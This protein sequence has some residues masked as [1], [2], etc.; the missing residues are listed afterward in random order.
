MAFSPVCG[1][2]FR[3]R[4][5]EPMNLGTWHRRD[6]TMSVHRHF[7]LQRPP[8][9]GPPDPHF[10]YKSPSHD[11]ALATLQYMLVADKRCCAVVGE[12]GAGKT[13][14]ARTLCALVSRNRIILWSDSI[15]SVDPRYGMGVAVYAR[16]GLTQ[17]PAERALGEIP[18]SRWRPRGRSDSGAPLLIVDDADALAGRGWG[19]ILALLTREQFAPRATRVVLLGL[20]RLRDVLARPEMTRIR[21]RVFRACHLSPFTAT[22]TEAY[23]RHRLRSAGAS[24]SVPFT[25]EAISAVHRVSQGNPAL[26]NQVCD[27]AMIEAWSRR[28]AHVEICDILAAEGSTPS[29]RGAVE[30]NVSESTALTRCRHETASSTPADGQPP[31]G[32]VPAFRPSACAQRVRSSEAHRATDDE[33]GA[34]RGL[35][36]LQARIDRALE[37]VR[38]MRLHAQG[39]AHGIPSS[40]APGTAAVAAPAEAQ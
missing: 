27:N 32:R 6:H 20:P 23:V 19:D 12:S 35:V 31:P 22:L 3:A 40:A 1:I 29:V 17:R 33:R 26:I 11:E 25:A 2:V 16:G 28:S 7:K 15:H 37:E 36:D 13:L 34:D 38:H 39:D 5:R 9:E 24:A 4:H 21:R 10:Y 18:L 30:T 14:L 8:F